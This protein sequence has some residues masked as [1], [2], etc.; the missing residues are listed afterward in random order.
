L[1]G[2]DSAGSGHYG[3]SRGQRV[4]LGID[5]IATPGQT[6]VSPVSGRAVNFVG[7]TLKKPMV[8]IIPSNSALGIDKI[9]LLYVNA[10]ANVSAWA[11][12]NVQAGHSVG[13]LADLVNE[14][15]YPAGITQHVH[16][17]VMVGG[18]WV[19]P[20]PYFFPVTK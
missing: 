1:R 3:A 15:H 10:P 5:I 19:D 12:Y 20:T 8:D 4:D 17:Q 13:T 9:R 18:Q 7:A 2:T 11:S 6:I 16:V 14:L